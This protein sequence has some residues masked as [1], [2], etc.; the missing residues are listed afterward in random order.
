LETPLIATDLAIFAPLSQDDNH[1]F[2][3]YARFNRNV[4]AAF[5]AHVKLLVHGLLFDPATA[6]ISKNEFMRRG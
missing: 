3:E 2:P 5:S 1:L 4:D 6:E